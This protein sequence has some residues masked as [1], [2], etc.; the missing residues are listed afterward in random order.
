MI[1][2]KILLGVCLGRCEYI[3]GVQA[4]SLVLFGYGV[5]IEMVLVDRGHNRHRLE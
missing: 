3:R 2:P 4:R 5:N 1:L